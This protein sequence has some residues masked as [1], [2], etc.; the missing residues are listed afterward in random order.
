M[1]DGGLDDPIEPEDPTDVNKNSS[2][3]LFFILHFLDFR[4]T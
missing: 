4:Q 1:D 2:A 3:L